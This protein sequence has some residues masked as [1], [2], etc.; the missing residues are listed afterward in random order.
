MVRYTI[1]KPGGMLDLALICLVVFITVLLS[2]FAPGSLPLELLAFLCIFFAPGW[3]ILAYAFP[4]SKATVKEEVQS[5]M[6]LLER[7]AASIMLSMLCFAVGGLLLAWS[8]FGLTRLTVLLYVLALTIGLS[9]LAARKRSTLPEGEAFSLSIEVAR[10]E[11]KMNGWEKGVLVLAV[12]GILI[13]GG[14]AAD[15][16][17][18]PSESGERFT[19]LFIT[20]L[21]GKVSSLPQTLSVYLSGTVLVH[22]RNEMHS[23]VQYNL[24]I[25]IPQDGNFSSIAPS[26]WQSS[27]VLAGGEGHS[28]QFI[29]DEGEEFSSPFTFRIPAEGRQQVLF[30]LSFGEENL[31][32]WLWVTVA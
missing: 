8:P 3:S 26:S 1:I 29:V 13:A 21:D 9:A 19:E 2:I 10:K 30:S 12:V 18:R 24:T 4:G 15:A 27:H 5:A 28:F 16:L 17:M 7:V 23:S 14:V 11:G 31:R 20:G 6:D 25:G 32:T 22:V